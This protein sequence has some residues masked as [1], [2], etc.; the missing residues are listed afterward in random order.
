MSP[1][2]DQEQRVATESIA[3]YM[4][5]LRANADRQEFTIRIEGTEF[6]LPAPAMKVLA[7]ILRYMS[8]G[9]AISVVPVETELST[10]QAADLMNVSRPHLVKIL[11]AG[12]IPF[13]KVGKHR[14]VKFVDVKTYRAKSKAER[15]KKLS[16][17]Q[18]LG[19]ELG[20]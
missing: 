10:Q 19:Q 4:E 9:K 1:V 11:E 6:S 16:A 7:K 12:E 3:P 5:V 14:R 20:I 13:E 8:E 17:L 2:T 18:K 15:R